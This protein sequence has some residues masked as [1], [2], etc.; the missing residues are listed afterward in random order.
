MMIDCPEMDY[1]R[2]TSDL[3]A[4]VRAYRQM[5]LQISAVKIYSQYLSDKMSGDIKN[6]AL[7]LYHM[8]LGWH[9]L[10]NIEM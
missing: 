4:F 3:G 10:M 7:T 8:K 6:K 1:Y 2:N 9:S 5:G